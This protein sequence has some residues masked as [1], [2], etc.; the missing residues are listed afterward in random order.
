MS[1]DQLEWLARLVPREILEAP[2]HLDSKD[3]KELLVFR[4]PLVQLEPLAQP[5]LLENR[6]HLVR[7]DLQ[8]HRV[9]MEQP[10]L[11]VPLVPLAL[12]VLRESLGTEGR[13]VLL[14]CRAHLE[15][16]ATK[17]PQV[18][19]GQLVLLEAQEQRELWD[20]S[21]MLVPP[22]VREALG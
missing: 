21:V 4:A 15:E 12:L 3:R 7:E 11:L 20:A 16:T 22:V 14:G 19:Q 5:D 1:P 8:G 2:V 17:V 10:E 13:T 18:N 6:E 9:Q